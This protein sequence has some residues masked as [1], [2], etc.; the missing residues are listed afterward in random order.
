M[1]FLLNMVIFHCYVSLPEGT[2]YSRLKDNEKLAR[3]HPKNQLVQLDF[4]V[5]GL[6]EIPSF[7]CGKEAASRPPKP[8]QP[9]CDQSNGGEAFTEN[10]TGQQHGGVL[11]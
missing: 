11:W 6:I 2:Y 4:P 3:S 9:F 10:T 7:I 5:Q 1:Y 8:T